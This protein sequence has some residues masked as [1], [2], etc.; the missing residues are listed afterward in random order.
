MA[1]VILVLLILVICLTII[2][3]IGALAYVR[4]Q[5]LPTRVERKARARL[6]AEKI[7]T[8]IDV[9]LWKQDYVVTARRE[10]EVPHLPPGTQTLLPP[11]K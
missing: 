8:E 2:V 6:T 7:Q 10:G 11:G 3:V 1:V 5:E 9:E 4:L